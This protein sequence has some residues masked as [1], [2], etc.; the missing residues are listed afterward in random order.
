[1][2][3]KNPKFFI[4]IIFLLLILNACKSLPGGDALKNPPDP[5]SVSQKILKKEK[6]LGCLTL[7]KIWVK[8]ILSSRA[9]MNYGEPHWTL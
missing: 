9:R 4:S 3:P 8:Q 2:K 7:Q 6:D 1:M 5:K